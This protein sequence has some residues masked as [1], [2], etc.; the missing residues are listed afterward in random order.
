MLL[1]WYQK[2]KNNC[3]LWVKLP[4]A[5]HTQWRLRTVAFGT[6]LQAGKLW[7]PIL[8]FD[9]TRPGM[10]P[11]LVDW[12]VIEWLI[13]YLTDHWPSGHRASANKTVH[14]GLIPG[15]VKP[16]ST[17]IAIHS[18]LASSSAIRRDNVKPPPCVAELYVGPGFS[19]RVSGLK[20]TKFWA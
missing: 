15:R 12:L 1:C 14:L 8:G 17:K 5:H 13:G 7:I 9:L 19:G 16:T 11:L 20:L 10:E 2:R 3:G 18:L 6:E 4:P